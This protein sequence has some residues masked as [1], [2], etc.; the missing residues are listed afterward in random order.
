MPN[1]LFGEYLAHV[2]HLSGHDVAEIL[3]D[4]SSSGRRFGEIA[5]SWGLCQPEHVWEA[6]ANQL[7]HHRPRVDLRSVGVDG[8]ATAAVP[9]R[10]ARRFR[11]VPIRIAGDALVVAAD[12]STIERAAVRLPAILRRPICFVVAPPEQVD[13]VMETYYPAPPRPAV[14]ESTPLD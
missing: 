13:A 1:R 7:A 11:A 6:W 10:L 4:Q 9:A 5:L 12:E 3:E 14:V 2:V 8:Q